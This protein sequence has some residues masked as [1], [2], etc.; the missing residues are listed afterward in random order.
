MES[1]ALKEKDPHEYFQNDEKKNEEASAKRKW[2]KRRVSLKK[3]EKKTRAQFV[4]R[5]MV[6]SVGRLTKEGSEEP[7]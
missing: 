2:E 7:V 3:E 1:R 5:L 4:G 6:K